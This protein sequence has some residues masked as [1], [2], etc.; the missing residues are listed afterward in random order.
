[1]TRMV[2]QWDSGTHSGTHAHHNNPPPHAKRNCAV[3]RGHIELLC[4][5]CVMAPTRQHP[6]FPLSIGGGGILLDSNCLCTTAVNHCIS[7]FPCIV[8]IKHTTVFA[9]E[10]YTEPIAGKVAY[11]II[12]IVILLFALFFPEW[13]RSR[14]TTERAIYLIFL[15]FSR[16]LAVLHSSC[17]YTDSGIVNL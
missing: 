4:H 1:M 11:L 12:R 10:L 7:L 17:T 8:S 9:S 14:S 16:F 2:V 5:Y 3:R 15:S 13:P 6:S